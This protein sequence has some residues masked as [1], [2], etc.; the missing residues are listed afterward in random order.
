MEFRKLMAFGNSSYIVSI[1]KAWI[2]KNRLKKGDVLLVEQKPNELVISSKDPSERRKINEVTINPEGKTFE[3]FKTEII[4]LYV[5]NYDII[6]VVNVKDADA[7]KDILRNLVGMEIIEETATK[8]V[9][10]D[11]LDIKE[12]SLENVMRRID[13]IIRSMLSDSIELNVENANSVVGRDKEINRLSLLG[14]RTAKAA[15]DNPRLLKLF[16]TTYWNVLIAKQVITY[17]ER[18]ADQIKRIIRTAKEEK[19][20][21]KAH[22]DLLKLLKSVN[23]NYLMVMKILY[24]KDRQAAIKAETKTRSL[25]KDCDAILRKYPNVSIVRFIEY[26]QH[27]V[28]AMKGVLR[29]VME[30]E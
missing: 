23:E 20:D 24:A 13:I 10:K 28:G 19:I 12:V 15:T 4:S 14:F 29:T 11:L 18:F 6:T 27:T 16:N 30:Y 26:F 25:L 17:L 1:P 3:E 22:A 8:I 21:K 7:I 9:A 2:E 5:N